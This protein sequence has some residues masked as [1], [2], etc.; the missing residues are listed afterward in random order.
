MRGAAPVSAGASAELERADRGDPGRRRLRRSCSRR[1]ATRARRSLRCASLDGAVG[2]GDVRLPR[3]RRLPAARRLRHLGAVGARAARRAAPRDPD[4]RRRPRRDD[5]DVDAQIA[6]VRAKVPDE[7]REEFDELLGEARLIYRLRD[8]RGVFSDIWASGIMRRAA[9]AAGRRLAAHGPHP[10]AG[11]L[12]RRR[13]RRD[14]RAR[15]RRRRAVGRRA[16]RT[17]R[18]PRRRTRPRT[19]RR[20]SARRRL[21]RRTRPGCR[22][23]V[24]R[25]MRATGIA[26]GALF[27]SS[28]A[29]HEEHL[30][31]GLAA[32]R[33]VVRGHGAPRLRPVRVRADRAGRR[34]RH[35]VDDGGVQHPA[36][37]A[38]RDRDGQR[39]PALALGDRRARVRHPR[40]RRDARGDRADRRRRARAR[41][42]RRGRGDG[43]R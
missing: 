3:P 36:A 6:G 10:R 15:D 8:E 39:R 35:R 18:V 16:R 14:V 7:H 26:L 2:R 31:R 17:R 34:P 9:L 37:A 41:R 22:R 12:R 30:L 20:R 13:L 27:G 1:T 43:P 25:L 23:P 40:R 33:G 4:G 28:E 38:R 42:R 11:A 5:A 21:R 24:A 19:R 29:E 32:S